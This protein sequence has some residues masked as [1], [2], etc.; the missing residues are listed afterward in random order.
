MA[1]AQNPEKQSSRPQRVDDLRSARYSRV[2][3]LDFLAF[4][5]SASA[6]GNCPKP[7]LGVAFVFLSSLLARHL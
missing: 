6:K 5:K 4:V 1:T 3:I 7:L 2:T